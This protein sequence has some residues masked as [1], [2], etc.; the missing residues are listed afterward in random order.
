MGAAFLFSSV[1]DP[2]LSSMEPGGRAEVLRKII[3]R[4]TRYVVATSL[5]AVI[6]GVAL[7]GYAF[8]YSKNL[9]VGVALYLLQAG[10]LVGLIALV[11][12]LGL[13]IPTARTISRM[14]NENKNGAVV[15]EGQTAVLSA[16]QSRVR[17]GT[18]TVTVLLFLVLV[19]MVV[20]ASI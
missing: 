5:T 14:L 20:G 6:F 16:M 18:M 7:Y 19:L 2:S 13:V 4:Y 11:V 3:P 12:A 15:P 10:A 1:L 8:E 17:M 9:P